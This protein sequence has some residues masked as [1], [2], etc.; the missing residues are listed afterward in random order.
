[1]REVSFVRLVL[2]VLVTKSVVF[3]MYVH[4]N[5]SEVRGGLRASIT[6]S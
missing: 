2:T 4:F 1:M 6:A 5:N 3:L